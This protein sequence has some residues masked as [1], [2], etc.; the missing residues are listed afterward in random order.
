MSLRD[1]KGEIYATRFKVE[2]IFQFSNVTILCRLLKSNKV[3][4]LYLI[5]N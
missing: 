1:G 2:N 5:L 4:F 3:T